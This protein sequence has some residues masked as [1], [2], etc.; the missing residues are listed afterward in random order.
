MGLTNEMVKKLLRGGVLSGIDI[1]FFSIYNPQNSSPVVSIVGFLLL[2]ATLY[3]LLQALVAVINKQFGITFRNQSK[4]ISIVTLVTGLLVA[5]QS[6]G[7]LTVKDVL[8]FI[9]L[10]LI[11]YFLLTY[12]KSNSTR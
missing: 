10:T 8:A 6:I 11:L 9:P 3:T 1:V 5:M 2:S 7:Q 12:S 4:A